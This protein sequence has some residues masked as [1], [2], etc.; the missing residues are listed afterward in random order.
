MLRF[1][2]APVLLACCGLAH[3]QSCGDTLLHDTTLAADLHCTTGS[4]LH[5]LAAGAPGITLDLGGHTLSGTLS[6]GVRVDGMGGVTIRNG[7]IRGF[8]V[9]ISGQQAHGL[10]VE[11]VVFEDMRFG[12]GADD[13]ASV[14]VAGNRFERLGV[15]VILEVFSPT[16]RG[17][18]HEI[19]SNLF[20]DLDAGITLCGYETGGS[21]VADNDMSGLG[22][23]GIHFY[24]GAGRNLVAGNAIADA[25]QAAIVLRTSSG[26]ELTGN[27]VKRGVKGIALVPD[28]PGYCE[29]GP[30]V[31]PE[32]NDNL[33]HGNSIFETDV[34]V[35]LGVDVGKTGTATGNKIRLNKLYYGG[36]GV[37]FNSDA[38][39][40]DATGNAYA[41]TTTPVV[42]R[43]SGNVY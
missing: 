6:F 3:A 30:V 22:R 37:R 39:G 40:N 9:G 33:I 5:A 42:D 12:V 24:N 11:N 43:G 26:N 38:H 19:S 8:A 1:L 20:Q 28:P 13:T 35:E 14:K 16:H 17:G 36:V 27:V 23:Y 2:L 7:R 32:A 34:A 25:A 31:G 41:G 29:D 10:V 21:L 15:G 4:G 18:G